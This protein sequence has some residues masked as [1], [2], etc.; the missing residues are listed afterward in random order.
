MA[1]IA[2]RSV[3]KRYGQVEAVKHLDLSCASGEMLALLG[4]SGCF[5]N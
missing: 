5:E 4:P 3:S 2:F 1:A